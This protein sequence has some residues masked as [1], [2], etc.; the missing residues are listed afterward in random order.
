M[1]ERQIVGAD[2]AMPDERLE[3]DNFVPVARSVKQDWDATFDLVRLHQCKY[4]HQ[5]IERTEA[6][7][8][9]H[10]RSGEMCEPELAHE[11]ITELEG[12]LGRHVTVRPLFLRQSDVE[13]DA[14]AAGIGSAAVGCLHDTPAAAAA[15]DVSSLLRWQTVRPQRDEARELARLVV[16]FTKR[17]IPLQPCGTEKH[18]RVTDAFAIERLQRLQVFGEYAQ[19][20]CIVTLSRNC[21]FL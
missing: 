19:R 6:S 20:T 8:K 17:A 12:Q 9:H 7:G 4:F 2:H 14:P 21:A 16:V 3:V 1:E 18:N 13:A 5:L 15:N 11:K 10:Q